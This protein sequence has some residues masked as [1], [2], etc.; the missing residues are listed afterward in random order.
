MPAAVKTPMRKTDRASPQREEE[1]F[2]EGIIKGLR[3]FKD[4]RITRFKNDEELADYLR[5]LQII[6]AYQPITTYY[7]EK[8]FKKLTKKD[9]I[10]Y[11]KQVS[12]DM[13]LFFSKIAL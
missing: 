4:G 2:A 3:D 13:Q 11:I 1:S 10:Y 6:M 5:N 8:R 12:Y 7:F 9:V